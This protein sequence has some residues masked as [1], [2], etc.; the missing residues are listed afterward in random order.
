MTVR[1]NAILI[2]C[3]ALCSPSVVAEDGVEQAEDRRAGFSRALQLTYKAQGGMERER[4]VFL[5]YPTEQQEIEFRY[6]SQSGMI[7]PDAPVQEGGHP[8]IVFSH[9]FWGAADQSVFLMEALAR[10]GYVV[11]SVHHDDATHRQQR[12]K[13]QM[14]N[15]F[16]AKEW[17]D[18]KF[19]DRKEDMSALLDFVLLQNKV[20]GSI[21]HQRILP[22]V[23][24]GA[25]HSLGGYT[26]L[27]MTGVRK[28]WKESRVK[29][30]LLLTPYILPYN[31]HGDFKRV[32]VPV[33]VQGGTWDVGITPFL[34]KFYEQ[35]T[36]S[37]YYLVLRG[38]GHY[39]WTDWNSIGSTTTE[40]L[41]EG[42]PKL[43]AEYS[44]AFFDQ[45]LRGLDRKEDLVKRGKQLATW[46]TQEKAE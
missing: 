5:W 26:I 11:A 3:A 2:T 31:H 17:K 33:M 39:G 13:V 20:V 12:A 1:F 46:L 35:L 23:V 22:G 24:G 4:K 41:K 43:I 25:G 32:D 9:G 16:K 28:S 15:F 18:D 10:A 36:T 44:I 34:K 30:A 14:P 45:H 21:L 29:A 19:F 40:A 6:A 38:A 37:K 42:N 8:L 7:A 27:G